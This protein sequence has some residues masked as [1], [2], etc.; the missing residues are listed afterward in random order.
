[1]NFEIWNENPVLETII[2]YHNENI[3]ISHLDIFQYENLYSNPPID[4]IN[5]K[6]KEEDVTKIKNKILDNLEKNNI[7][8]LDLAIDLYE[9]YHHK[10]EYHNK[11]CAH[12]QELLKR[13]IDNGYLFD[14]FN[15]IVDKFYFYIGFIR[16]K[17]L[18]EDERLVF[19]YFL[20]NHKER[21]LNQIYKQ[22]IE[23]EIP[24]CYLYVKYRTNSIL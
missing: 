23:Y 20:L 19:L 5:I 4:D 12:L 11:I 18:E 22:I 13:N 9:Y 1:P 7:T 10:I 17:K 21:K 8:I 15:L 24:K 16:D 14:M 3:I 2:K 6:M